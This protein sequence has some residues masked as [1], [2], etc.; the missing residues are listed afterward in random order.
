MTNQAGAAN[1]QERIIN[2]IKEDALGGEGRAGE[3]PISNLANMFSKLNGDESR[4][5]IEAI[6][7]LVNARSSTF[8]DPEKF[9]RNLAFLSQY[10]KGD[11]N[12]IKEAFFAR[13]FGLKSLDR[14]LLAWALF[15]YIETS[16]VLNEVQLMDLWFIREKHPILWLSAAVKSGLFE[17]VKTHATSMLR[18]GKITS[19]NPGV[20]N[21]STLVASLASWMNKW[22]VKENFFKIVEDFRDAA[23]EFE[24]KKKLKHWVKDRVIK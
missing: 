9:W 24:T 14:D 2:T 16:G 15:G 7:D 5:A 8:A 22:P 21:S 19:S 18:E 3:T 11:K 10:P 4:E 20:S 17:F 1:I 6:A 23:S 13:L 12:H